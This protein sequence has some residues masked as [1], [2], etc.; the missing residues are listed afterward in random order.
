MKREGLR[1]GVVSEYPDGVGSYRITALFVSADNAPW[2]ARNELTGV[3][4]QQAVTDWD[5]KG[6]RTA[7]V[8]VHDTAGGPRFAAVFVKDGRWWEA[9]HGMTADA[10]RSK[11]SLLNSQGCHV[12]SVA[13]YHDGPALRYAAVWGKGE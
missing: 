8:C 5:Q 4:F 12:V 1:P 6:Y 3:Q 2:E 11:S 13:C 10:Y 7:S 9:H